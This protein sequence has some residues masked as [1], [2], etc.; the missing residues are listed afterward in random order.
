MT[1]AL[2]FA[3]AGIALVLIGA[4]V[5]YQ[6]S[7]VLHYRIRHD[8]KSLYRVLCTRFKPGDSCGKVNSLLGSG[9]EPSEAYRNRLLE[10][11]HKCPE[12]YP[13]GVLPTD[14]FLNYPYDGSCWMSLQFRDR[15]LVNH[16][17]AQF[18][19]YEP[20]CCLAAPPAGSAKDA[21]SSGPQAPNP[22]A[23]AIHLK[24]GPSRR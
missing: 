15:R 6:T 18:T 23:A 3:V 10:A 22:G 5:L 13:D 11:V 8:G 21:C 4:G 16:E 2:I 7:A 1:D 20:L 14:V 17:P 9:K 19:R 12:F 24:R